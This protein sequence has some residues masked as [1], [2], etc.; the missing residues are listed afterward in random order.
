M[1]APY[2]I[3]CFV[4]LSQRT[5]VCVLCAFAMSSSC[6][7]I[8]VGVSRSNAPHTSFLIQLL[9]DMILQQ[10]MYSG[11]SWP[12]NETLLLLLDT[13]KTAI[14]VPGEHTAV[15]SHHVIHSSSMYDHDGIT[16]QWFHCHE[17]TLHPSA[18]SLNFTHPSAA[19]R[20]NTDAVLN[21]QSDHGNAMAWRHSGNS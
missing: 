7:S 9:I 8:G 3:R 18:D 11:R 14:F 21:A 5:A 6:S 16:Q 17:R 10:Y 4:Y 15:Y 20:S 1:G 2:D 13:P 19:E 12:T